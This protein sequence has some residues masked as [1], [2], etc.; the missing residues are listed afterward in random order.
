V[1]NTG[2]LALA[3]AA[4][5]AAMLAWSGTVGRLR[6]KEP[7]AR[8]LTWLAG[9]MLAASA[10]LLGIGW[11]T[12]QGVPGLLG[13]RLG[14]LA[15]AVTGLLLLAGLSAAWLHSRAGELRIAALPAWRRGV[16]AA[17]G[18]LALLVLML[19]FSIWRQ[20]E[21]ALTLANW[22]FAWR[23]DPGLPVS[24]HTWNRLWLALAQSAAALVLLLCALFARRLRL[25]LLGVAA[26][27][28]FG[29]SWP[30]PRMLLTEAH[31][32]SYQR[33]P[34]AFSDA[35]VLQG[36]RLYRQHCASCHGAAADGRGTRAAG[37]PAWPSVLGAALFD[38]RLEGELYWRVAQGGE[39]PAAPGMHGFQV[40]LG[41]DEIWRVLDYLRLQA[42]G[43]SGG[44]GMPAIPA[45][46]VDLVC[47]DGRASRLSGL[48]GLPL[49]VVAHVKDAPDEPQDPRMLTVA[50]TRGAAVDVNA[51]CVAASAGAW[52]AYALAAGV[53]PDGVA[54]AQFMVDR[55]GWLRARRLPGAAPAWTSADNVCGPGGRMEN[56]TARGLGELLMAMDRAPID[57]PVRTP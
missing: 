35:N 53:P 56:T 5:G 57:M 12:V 39:A 45:P 7:G 21:D 20:P 26:V 16:A 8:S 15:L 31:G 9:G 52:D 29:A 1:V 47:R 6:V 28:A 30:H 51:D 13:S 17:V 50:L 24:P 55:R 46:V 37:L 14:H 11:R 38:N 19:A 44:A 33:S 41:P 34:L 10:A 3:V 18:A 36:G 32:T 42:Y 4:A 23:Y 43:A 40:M 22:P 2:G 49:R 27:L 25:V 48:R 54:G